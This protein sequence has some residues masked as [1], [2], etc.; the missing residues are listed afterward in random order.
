MDMNILVFLI[1][2][3]NRVYIVLDTETNFA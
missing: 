3:V 1:Y 2:D